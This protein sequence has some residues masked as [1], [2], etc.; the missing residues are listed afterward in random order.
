MPRPPGPGETRSMIRAAGRARP[1]GPGG[2]RIGSSA[3]YCAGLSQVTPV[4]MSSAKDAQS[5]LSFQDLILR[6]QQY[7][8][9]RGCVGCD[10]N[11]QA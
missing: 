9:E 1:P 6:L 8:A 3:L 4:S 11:G 7:W 10:H 2:V 5:F